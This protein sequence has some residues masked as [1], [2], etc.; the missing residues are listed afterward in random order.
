MHLFLFDLCKIYAQL[1]PGTKN[2]RLPER[3]KIIRR[4]GIWKYPPTRL[5]VSSSGERSRV[6]N[7]YLRKAMCALESLNMFKRVSTKCA[8]SSWGGEGF[9]IPYAE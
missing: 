1:L 5:S 9:G 6:R 4:K 8:L 2:V 7:I 3:S